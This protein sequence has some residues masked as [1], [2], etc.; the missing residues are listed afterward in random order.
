MTEHTL[1]CWLYHAKQGGKIYLSDAALVEA[2]AQGWR[3]SPTAALEA[4]SELDATPVVAHI[5]PVGERQRA[6]QGIVNSEEVDSESTVHYPLSTAADDG[7]AEAPP[8]AVLAATK[9]RRR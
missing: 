2:H 4:A 5:E 8:V 1:P 3:D 6:E 9:K 7:A